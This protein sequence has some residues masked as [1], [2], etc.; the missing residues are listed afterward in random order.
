MKKTVAIMVFVLSV[1]GLEAQDISG[2]WNG[3]LK[4]QGMQ[5]R[6]VFNISKTGTGYSSTMDSPDQGAKGIPVTTTTFVD[7]KLKLEMVNLKAEFNGE[8]KE[9]KFEG[10]FKQNGNEFP[11]TLSRGKD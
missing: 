7:A 2:Q 4:V 8:L 11:M 1:L 9:N 5:L 6:I 10:T 3:A